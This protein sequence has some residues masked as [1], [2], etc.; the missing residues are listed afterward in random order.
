MD[1]GLNS[2]FL[3]IL[4]CFCSISGMNGYFLILFWG[5]FS[6]KEEELENLRD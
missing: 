2:S 4:M 1:F 6:Q 5:D 3:C